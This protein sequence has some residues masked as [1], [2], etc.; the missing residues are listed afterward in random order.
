MKILVTGA[1]GFIGYHV[2]KQLLTRGDT[3][4]GIDNMNA[5]YSVALKDARI[6]QFADH[7]GFSFHKHD[8]SDRDHINRLF[9]H[10]SFDGVVHLAAQA[11][12][13]HSLDHPHDYV[14]SNLVGLV[15]IL[16]ACRHNR[17]THLVFASSSSVYGGRTEG[18][19]RVEDRVD[20]PIS[21]YAATKKSGE[22]MAHSYSHLFGLPI[23]CLRFFT[24]YGPWGRPD[25]AYFKFAEKIEANQPI[26]VF[27]N[28]EMER[29]FTYV[30]D[31]VE[32]IVRV[33]DGP[34]KP[35]QTPYRVYNIGRGQ[36]IKLMTFIQRIEQALGKVA[37]KELLPMQPGDVPVTWAD[38]AALKADH[39]Y[40]PSTS[41]EEGISRFIEWY[42]SEWTPRK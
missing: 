16:E 13:R 12:V 40:E 29:D 30:D 35:P 24:V 33:L 2:S 11:G 8:I 6:S 25:M 3:V 19:F 36:P 41:L 31:V 14:D 20:S 34:P 42:L 26:Q 1:A 15:N 22:L 18:P 21:L 27:N 32:G 4:V 7:P 39:G 17:T 37:Q 5:Y 10:E 38:V 28:G 9:E 23:S